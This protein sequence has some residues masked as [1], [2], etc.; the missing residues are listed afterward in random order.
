[1][2]EYRTVD[3]LALAIPDARTHST[4]AIASY[5]N[6]H[7]TTTDDKLRAVYTWLAYNIRYDL[8]MLKLTEQEKDV[9]ALVSHALKERRGVCFQFA[10]LF[11]EIAGKLGVKSYTVSG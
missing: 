5:I 4:E 9:D 11:H 10:G 6:R 8:S 7:F 3:S 2:E 1:M